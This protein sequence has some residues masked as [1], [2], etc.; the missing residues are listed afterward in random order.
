MTDLKMPEKKVLLE[1]TDSYRFGKATQFGVKQWNEAIDDCTAF[2][3]QEIAKKDARIAELESKI[4][5]L[6]VLRE[7]W[8]TAFGSRQLT[9]AI[10]NFESQKRRIAELERQLVEAKAGVLSVEEISNISIK[11]CE[12]CRAYSDRRL[13]GVTSGEICKDIAQ[14]IHAAMV[15][16]KKGGKQ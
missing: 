8:E 15:E 2:Y 5:E 7:T 12:S 16:K 10:D 6:N 9:H 3:T 11:V 4:K 14:S 13:C 1:R